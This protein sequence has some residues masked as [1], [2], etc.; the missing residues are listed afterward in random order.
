[1]LR[2]IYSLL[3][4]ITCLPLISGQVLATDIVIEDNG[5]N[6]ENEVVVNNTQATEVTQTNTANITNNITTNSNTGGN[7]TSDNTGGETTVSTGDITTEVNATNIGNVSAV[8]SDCC[9][10]SSDSN[11]TIQGNGTGSQNL[12]AANITGNSTYQ[13]YQT[14]FVQ[15]NIQN[16]ANTGNNTAVDNSDSVKIETGDI[17]VK[18]S[19]SNQNINLATIKGGISF[20][21]LN[22]LISGNGANSDNKIT[23]NL[24]SNFDI[25]I[26]NFAVIKNSIDENANTG[27]NLVEGNSSDVE[28]ETGDIHID[29][30]I[31]NG[32]INSTLV[33]ADCCPDGSP[34]PADPDDNKQPPATTGGGGGSGG[35]SPGS[36]LGNSSGG[37]VLAAAIGSAGQ[38]L[39]ATGN[40]M[41]ILLTFLSALMFALGMYLRLHPGQDPGK[42]LMLNT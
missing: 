26:D 11:L 42:N 25:F 40:S 12:I 36:G 14:A 31:D 34:V 8:S 33:S 2:K 20:L 6:S 1:M 41:T 38:I 15:N 23:S 37:Q 7:I 39:P 22:A 5:S 29:D 16:Y 19:L 24:A 9:T 28:I 27:G 35:S 17:S 18:S 32:P 30:V 4:I 3:I 10:T 13:V 21:S